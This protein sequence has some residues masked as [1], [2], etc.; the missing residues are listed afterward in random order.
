MAVEETPLVRDLIIGG[1]VLT[2][3]LLTVALLAV[4]RRPCKLSLFRR[5]VLKWPSEGH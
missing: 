2:F 5:R 3:V 1:F 4:C